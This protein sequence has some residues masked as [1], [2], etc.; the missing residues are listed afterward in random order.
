VFTRSEP[1]GA[2][3][4]VVMQYDLLHVTPP[5]SAPEFVK[6]SPLA[7]AAGYAL[8]RLYWDG[9]LRGRA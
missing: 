9:M 2:A 1:G 6:R 8:P 7:D 3:E 4:E 5:M